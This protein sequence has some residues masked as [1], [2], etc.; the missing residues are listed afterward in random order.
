M[1]SKLSG[2]NLQ[3]QHAK[4]HLGTVSEWNVPMMMLTKTKINPNEAKDV[5]KKINSTIICDY[6]YLHMDGMLLN[7]NVWVRKESS[8]TTQLEQERKGVV[9]VIKN[10]IQD[11]DV[12]SFG[13]SKE[14]EK[15]AGKKDRYTILH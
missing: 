12:I 11:M 14:T 9:V 3:H 8:R 6:V 13:A 1:E 2:L 15:A 10:N 5:M 7:L 4:P